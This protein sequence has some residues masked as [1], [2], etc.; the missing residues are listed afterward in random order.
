LAWT[1]EYSSQADKALAKLDRLAARR[2]LVFMRDR[3][4]DSDD[5]RQ[6]GK[7]TSGPLAGYWRYRVGDYRVICDIQD[8]KLI[9]LVVTIGHRGDIYR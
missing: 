7:A 2:I 6:I 9:V 1:I 8:K 5:P 4:R 3:V